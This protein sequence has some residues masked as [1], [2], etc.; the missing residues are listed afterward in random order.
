VYKDERRESQEPGSR[1]E[2]EGEQLM[3]VYIKGGEGDR[4]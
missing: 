2:E 3:Y 4:I 1:V